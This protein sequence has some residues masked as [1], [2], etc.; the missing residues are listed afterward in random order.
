MLA[1]LRTFVAVI[2]AFLFLLSVPLVAIVAVALLGHQGPRADSWLVVRLSGDLLE[3]YGPTTVRDLLEDPPPCLM[4]IT[5]NLEK[6]AA[7][8]RIRGVILKLEGFRA[9]TGKLDEIRSGVARVR[10]AGKPT[11]AWAQTLDDAG[12]YLASE[13]DST[14]LFPEGHVFLLGRGVTIPHVKGTLE[15]LEVRD[16]FHV[17]DEYKTA[18]E[19]FTLKESSPEALE[20]LRWLVEDLDAAFDSTLAANRGLGAGE[21]GELR[22]RAVLG[23][24][25][26]R[27]AGLVDDLVY[28]DEVEDRLRGPLDELRTISSQD[29]S[30]VERRSLGLTGATK[31]AVVHGQGFIAPD[32]E[33]RYDPVW[34]VVMGPDRVVEDLE[35]A[36]TDHGVD[37]ILLRWDTPGGATD[38][39]ERVARAVL[40]ARRDKPV[41]VSMADEAASGGYMIS[42][43]AH[44][45]VC[46]GSGITGS[47][48]SITGKLNLRGLWAKLGVTFDDVAF[49]PNAFL[50]SE[51]HDWTMDQRE[52]VAEEHWAFYRAWVEDIAQAR[53]LPPEH[54]DESGRGKVWT[55]RQARERGLVDDLGGFEEAAAAVRRVAELG[56]DE[57][58]DFEHWPKEQ[59]LLDILLSGDLGRVALAEVIARARTSLAGRASARP[60]LLWEPL[61]V[62]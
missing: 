52:I 3:W 21:V 49:A 55:G 13:C 22:A 46:P 59:T 24:E 15:R 9:G 61:R 14:F 19:F 26:A 41:V 34:G 5:E 30:Q 29:Y 23:A 12:V 40:R 17:I 25:D 60:F 33:D 42:Y 31:V 10:D 2:A 7:D 44:R 36:R 18:A 54:V 62:R 53:S 45:I 50:F 37:A 58:L 39:S 48:G 4:E 32:G 57:K 20:N 38:G 35:R 8:R 11:Y 47:I 28:W 27:Q 16:Q 51:L 56:E 6:A 43:G 1:F